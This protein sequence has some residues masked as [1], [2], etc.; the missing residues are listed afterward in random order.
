MSKNPLAGYFR[1]PELYMKLPTMGRFNPEIESTSLDEVGVCA[2]TAIDEISLKNPDA[3][4]NGEALI[5][6]IQSCVPS[7][8]DARKLSN[9]DAEAI[10]M[11]IQYAT[12]GSDI[13][14]S[15]KCKKCEEVSEY[16]IDINYVLNKFPDI[17]SVDPIEWNNLKIHLRPPSIDSLTRLAIMELEQKRVVA[18]VK[19][20]QENEKDESRI[21]NTLYSSFRKIAE[22]NV[23][24]L[25][26]T[27]RCIETQEGDMIDD[28]IFIKDFMHNIPSNIVDH[29]QKTAAEI[30]K[31]PE[32]LTKFE[33]VCP[34][35]EH[36]DTVDLEV[37][38]VNFFASG[39]N[40]P[41]KKKL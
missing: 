12:Y 27:I 33:F 28:V 20:T 3:L 4:L 17:E 11:A 22:M 35:C 14:H 8:S 40:A 23:D 29:I 5:S 1:K 15:H 41:H 32:D 24:L 36:N 19:S 2:M 16:S 21:I 26:N 18:S 30:A 10:F 13:T 37:N 31:K 6:I 25:V 9:I 38:P 7:I 39:S 34:E